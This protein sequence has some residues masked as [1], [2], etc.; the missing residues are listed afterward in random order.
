METLTR[1][2]S[3]K[4][5]TMDMECSNWARVAHSQASF[6]KELK[7]DKDIS[8]GSTIAGIREDSGMKRWMER[9]HIDGLMEQCTKGNGEKVK[10][11]DEVH[12]SL[13]MAV[14]I[15]AGSRTTKNTDMV[16]TIGETVGH[17]WALGKMGNNMASDHSLKK[18]ASK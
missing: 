9:E 5:N 14:T 2:N 15:Q 4:A 12:S 8:N 10:C 16:S 13:M 11:M 7:M 17:I 3:K 18:T 6:I 1:A